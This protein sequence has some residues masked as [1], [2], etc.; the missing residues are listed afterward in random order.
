MISNK[1]YA[2]ALCVA[3]GG[4][5]VGVMHHTNKKAAETCGTQKVCTDKQGVACNTHKACINDESCQCYCSKECG[6]R[7]KKDDDRP[8][9]VENDPNGKYCY[10]KQWDL[11]NYEMRDCPQKDK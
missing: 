3:C 11:D 8:V 10:C 9:W 1:W 7:D 5:A 6:M 4:I 2:V